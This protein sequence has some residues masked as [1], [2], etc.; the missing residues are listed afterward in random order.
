[1]TDLLHLLQQIPV[2][3]IASTT[4]LGLLVG[5]FLNVV[6]YRLPVMLKRD[7]SRECY[8]FLEQPLP[9]NINNEKFNLFFP[10]SRC[11]HC[12]TPIKWWQNIPVF[13]FLF[14]K[15]RCAQCKTSISWRYPLVELLTAALSGLVA[16]KLG[17]GLP[18]LSCL[19]L[20]WCLIALSLIDY[21]EMILP[22]NIVLPLI[23]LGLLLSLYPIFIDSKQAIIGA[24]IGYLSLWS[25][26]HLFKLITGKEGMGYGDFK[27]LSVFG[28]W[29]GWQSIPQIIVLSAICGS[30]VGI[31]L[32]AL[33]KHVF[34]KPIPF[35]P[36]IAAAGW[37]TLL[38]GPE[39]SH[40]Y[41]HFVR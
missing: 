31:L 32:I 24:A 26:F 29:L 41:W 36:Y 23:W 14:L 20:T 21:D 3:L 38:Y 13:S 9:G 10:V 18:L 37:L 6:I 22:D 4:F 25:V 19:F 39:I 8:A 34:S 12:N 7:W 5:S 2:F 33:K 15:G 1:M 27:L 16:Y 17:Y 40:A 11:G 28:A 35:G 30:V